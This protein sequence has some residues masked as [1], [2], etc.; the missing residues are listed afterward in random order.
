MTTYTR[1]DG[2][3]MNVGNPTT[4]TQT[5]VAVAATSTKL[6]DANLARKV[7]FIQNIS[8]TD[9]DVSLDGTAA[10]M[11]DGVR[12]YA[13]G[14]ALTLSAA[15][16]SLTTAAIYAISTSGDNKAVRVIEGV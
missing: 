15:D 8:A 14:D 3:R 16:G 10:T 13:N 4:F 2:L 5:E 9:V 7:L 6:C 1:G 12:L 11:G